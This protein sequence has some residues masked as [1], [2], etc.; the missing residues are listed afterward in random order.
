[1]IMVW[2]RKVAVYPVINPDFNLSTMSLAVPNLYSFLIWLF[3]ST[4]SWDFQPSI[5]LT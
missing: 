1:M 3:T 4:D 5:M 2:Y